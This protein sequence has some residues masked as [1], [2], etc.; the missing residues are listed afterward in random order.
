MGQLRLNP[1][2][3]DLGLPDHSVLSAAQAGARTLI[4]GTAVIGGAIPEAWIG[5]L[6][7][8]LEAGLNVAA[9]VHTRLS[10]IERLVVAAEKSGRRLIDV[11][12][13]PANIPVGTG[14][15]RSGKRILTVGT[16]C[17]LGKKYTALALE[18]EMASRGLS[19]DFRATG[20][21][22]IMIAGQGIPIDAVVA[23]FVS[24]AAELV[25]PANDP[26]H[27]D[28]IEGQGS[29]FHPGYSAVSVGLLMGSQPDAFVV[30]TQAG[31]T[32]IEGWNNFPL[33]SV[34]AVIDRTIDIG[35]Q[36]NPA[37]RCVGISANTAN[38]DDDER[39]AYLAELSATHGL[40]AVDPLIT[41]VGAI[42]DYLMAG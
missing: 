2:T 21:T 39:T 18:A 37:I 24:G 10:S 25:S 30:C 12:V 40:P 20:Q 8:A 31:R 35:R 6:V 13:P 15:K 11:R 3:V 23:D 27:W 41:G 42:V 38:L 26:E 34:Q 9:G 33:P 29:V 14:V 32:H 28:V 1:D 4:I 17:A 16:D 36:V 22:G 19:V 7:E 5:L